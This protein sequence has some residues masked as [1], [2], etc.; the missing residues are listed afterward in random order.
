MCEHS[1]IFAHFC[2]RDFWPMLSP[3]VEN[4]SEMNSLFCGCSSDAFHAS[5]RTKGLCDA[6]YFWGAGF[7]G[8]IRVRGYRFEIW[9]NVGHLLFLKIADILY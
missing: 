8:F 5:V 4:C 2:C 1:H 6:G 3:R 9:R 7:L